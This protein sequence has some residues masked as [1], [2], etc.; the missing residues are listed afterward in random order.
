MG[1]NAKRANQRLETDAENARLKAR[2]IR[3]GLAA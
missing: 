1:D 2:Y 3:H